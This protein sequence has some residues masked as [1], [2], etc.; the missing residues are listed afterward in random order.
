M[1]LAAVLVEDIHQIREDKQVVRVAET[2]VDW[3]VVQM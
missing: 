1:L 3:V 2:Q